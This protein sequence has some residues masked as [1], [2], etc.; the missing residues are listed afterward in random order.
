MWLALVEPYVVELSWR[1]RESGTEWV[2]F[3]ERC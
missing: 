2:L 1:K 3:L